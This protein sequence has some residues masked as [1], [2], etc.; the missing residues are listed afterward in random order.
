M[1][2]ERGRSRRLPPRLKAGRGMS[3]AASGKPLAGSTVN[4]YLSQAGSI[5]KHAKRLLRGDERLDHN[6]EKRHSVL[7]RCR[8]TTTLFRGPW[9]PW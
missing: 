2:W 7:L 1:Y 9:S 3:T 4:R 8:S 6:L 5:F